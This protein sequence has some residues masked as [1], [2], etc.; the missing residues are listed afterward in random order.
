MLKDCMKIKYHRTEVLNAVL[1]IANISRGL[2]NENRLKINSLID[3]ILAL[4]ETLLSMEEHL[5]P[6]FTARR[7]L[8]VHSEFL[9]H[10]YR[11]RSAIG[12]I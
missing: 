4:N 10:K 1:S 5:Q 2:I 7:F 8:L 9:T 12:N 3:S 11:L 6:L